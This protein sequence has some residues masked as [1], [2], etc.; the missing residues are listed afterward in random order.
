MIGADVCAMRD[1]PAKCAEVAAYEFNAAIVGN[2]AVFVG[3]VEVGCAVFR[4]FD[5]NFV[6]VADTQDEIVEAVGPNFP[7]K[8]GKRALVSVKIVSTC[9][10][11]G[12]WIG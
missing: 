7:S 11:A 10:I 6:I 12:F 4:D 3:G 2:A 5:W 8:I 1:G 9:S